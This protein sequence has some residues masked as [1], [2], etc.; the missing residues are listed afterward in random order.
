MDLKEQRLRKVIRGLVLEFVSKLPQPKPEFNKLPAY[1]K[2]KE[3]NV[4]DDL[5]DPTNAGLRDEFFKPIDDS[6]RK[7]LG[8][9]NAD[10]Q[11]P[12]DLMNPGKNDYSSFLAWDID[13]DPHPDVIRGMK[14]KSGYM[15]LSLSAT[16]GTPAAK[17]Y[18]KAD[19]VKRLLDGQHWAEMSGPAAGVAMKNQVP[20]ITNKEESMALVNKRNVIWYGEH[21]YFTGKPEFQKLEREALYSKKKATFPGQYDGWYV[22]MLGKPPKPHVKMVFGKVATSSESN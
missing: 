16:D 17:D 15:K 14:P 1:A 13:Q 20:A 10:I 4:Y 12:A 18:A 5:F 3:V 8:E 6:Y 22:R 11:T 2:N 21:P 7:A 9:P 19:T